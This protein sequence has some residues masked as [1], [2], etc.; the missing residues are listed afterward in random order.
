MA[1]VQ[2]NEQNPNVA[3]APAPGQGQAPIAAG[4]AGLA[5]GAKPKDAAANAPG[6]NVPAQPSTQLSA[7][8]TANQPQAAQFA[9]QVAGQV[10]QQVASAGA[11]ILPAVNTYTGAIVNTPNDPALN[12]QVQTA[13]GSLTPDQ[14]AAYE[15]ELAAGANPPNA[16]GTFET[17]QGYQD[18]AGQI[19]QATEQANLWNAGNN[20]AALAIALQPYEAPNATAGDTTLDALLLSQSPGAYG[21]IQAATAPAAGLQD[22]LTAATTGADTALQSAIASDTAASQGATGAAQT[23]ATDLT[24]Y[25]NGQVA[26]NQATQTA[27]NKAGATLNTDLQS[28]KLTA[29]DAQAFGIPADQAQAWATNYDTLNADVGKETGPVSGPP[30]P[31]LANYLTQ[32]TQPTISDA[33]VASGQNY[34]DVAALQQMLGAGSPITLPIDAGTAS[35]AG[36]GTPTGAASFDSSGSQK[37]LTQYLAQATAMDKLLT[38]MVNNPPNGVYDPAIG[39][40]QAQ[41]RQVVSDLN[42]LLGNPE[43]YTLQG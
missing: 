15:A 2:P 42:T 6:Q 30:R 3:A 17:T 38:N 5:G 41:V 21:Q 29:A 13:P 8:L 25:L 11:G 12:Q 39:A 9:G 18:L 1:V 14:Q 10:G 37:A 16:A 40:E 19:Q 22:Q 36:T 27:A 26:A 31:N 35:Q 34:S 28:G 7:Y 43:T 4:G 32:P 33:T 24:N 20:P 23:Y